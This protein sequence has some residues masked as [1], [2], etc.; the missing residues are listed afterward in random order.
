MKNVKYILLTL[1]IACIDPICAQQIMDEK[2]FIQVTG[3][4]Q[5]RVIPNQ[6]FINIVLEERKDGK[7][8]ISI[9][10]QEKDMKTA[11]HKL[12]IPIENMRAVDLMANYTRLGWN[13]KEVM[14]QSKYMLEVKNAEQVSKVFEQFKKLE[15]KNANVSHVDHSDKEVIQKELR[16]KAIKNAKKQADDQLNAIGQKTGIPLKI[17][18]SPSSYLPGELGFFRTSYDTDLNYEN[19]SFDKKIS[20]EFKKIEFNQ[21]VYV[22]FEIE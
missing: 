2:D 7:E 8:T 15:I 17:N 9:A 4:A 20:I 10:Q 22:E 14:A 6:I 16:I 19:A 12:G 21:S 11:I 13:K 18:V 1:L 5:K 3:K